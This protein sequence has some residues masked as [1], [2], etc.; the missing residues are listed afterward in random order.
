MMK[1]YKELFYWYKGFV[2]VPAGKK[3]FHISI[4]KIVINYLLFFRLF[5]YETQIF[6]KELNAS[7]KL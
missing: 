7:K 6:R 4:T 3:L 2:Y 5:L 1:E